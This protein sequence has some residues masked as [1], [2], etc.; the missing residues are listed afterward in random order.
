MQRGTRASRS[1]RR[2]ITRRQAISGSLAG[3]LGM[4]LAARI[5]GAAPRS[6]KPNFVFLLADDLGYAD[7][8]CYG[9]NFST[10]RIDSLA[11][12]GALFS[13]A[14]AAS[15]VCSA[16]RVALMTGRYP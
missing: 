13:Q 15:S 14:Y 7:L 16:T 10:P 3:A 5:D 2:A 11:R 8:S 4:G 6:R 12:D 1:T 9:R